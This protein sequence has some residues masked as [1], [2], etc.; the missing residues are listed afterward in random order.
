MCEPLFQG[1]QLVRLRCL[2]PRLFYC[3][4][5]NAIVDRSKLRCVM[6]GETHRFVLFRYGDVLIRRKRPPPLHRTSS[7]VKLQTSD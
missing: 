7:H 1:L 4:Q 2:A 5:T 6:F 3:V